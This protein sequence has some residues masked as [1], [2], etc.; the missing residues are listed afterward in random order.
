MAKFGLDLY[1]ESYYGRDVLVSYSVGDFTATQA[2]YGSIA[3]S[4]STPVQAQNWGS[5]RIIRNTAGYPASETDGDLLLEFGPDAPSNSFTDSN[6][7]GGRFYY[8]SV[9]LSSAF[10]V[11]DSGDIYQAGDTVSYNGSN[12]ICLVDNTLGVAPATGLTQWQATNAS[13]TWNRAGQACSLAVA[14]Y[15]YR[16]RLYSLLP[17]PYATDQEEI[18]S[19]Q[20]PENELLF[21]YLSVLAWGLDMTRT[22]L[23]DQEHLHRV[24][25]MPLYRME[26]LAQQL[27]VDNEASITPRLRRVRASNAAASARRKGTVEAIKEAVYDA[28]GYDSDVSTSKNL[29][30]DADQAEAY[31]PRWPLWDPSVTYQAGAVVS[32]NGF[33][34]SASSNTIRLEAELQTITL[35]GAP[36]YTV[37]A[38]TATAQ[39][40]GGQQVLIRSN[41]VNQAATF[42]ITIPST[43]SYDLS[44]GMS[45][46]PGFGIVNFA[47]DD[48]TVTTNRSV[49][50]W[51]PTS[52]KLAF[53]GYASSSSP[54]SSVYLG[55]FSLTAGT[56]TIQAKVVAKNTKATGTDNGY[57]MGVD[58]ITYTPQGANSGVGVAPTGAASNNA[59]W[60]YYT[61]KLTNVLD[62]VTSGGISTWE[63][64]SFTAGA[65][66]NNDSL[67]VYSGYKALNGVGD[68]RANL[69]VMTNG[70]GV[71]AT[72]A[73]HSIPRARVTAWNAT[74]NYAQG[75]Y[76][77]YGGANYICLLPT[78]GTAPDADLTHW[79]PEKISTTGTDR[80]LVSSYGIPLTQE[81]MWSGGKTYAPGDVVQYQGQV[82]RATVAVKGTAPTGFPTDNASWAWNMSARN[83]YT[84]SAYTSRYTGSGTPSRSIYIEW[85][86]AAGNL[87]TTI[88]PSTVGTNPDLFV[89]FIRNSTDVRNDANYAGEIAGLSWLKTSTDTPVA[90]SGL[91]YWGT[92]TSNVGTTTGRQLFFTYDRA[93]A[94]NVGI[95]FMTAPPAGVEHGIAFR[96]SG[97]T[98]MWSV[99]R[100][101]LAKN[102]AGTLT[103]MA[104]WP[105]LLDGTRVYVQLNGNAITVYR[106]QGAGLAPLQLASVT[107]AFNA[108]AAGIALF[109]RTY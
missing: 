60:T 107:D 1:G 58:Y 79:R 30:L 11:Y 62:N 7:V 97:P 17:T 50:T 82:Y 46:A 103:T 91:F 36:S 57:Q 75:A 94:I 108:T 3:L 9:F 31:S 90:S 100:T 69:A 95:T 6:L 27:G 63:Q 96:R 67:D 54:A 21:R 51:P 45:K 40:S 39:F 59:F 73:A 85:F 38:N 106:Y 81:S 66:A 42:T 22:E 4:W 34:Y 101:R 23:G 109:E 41:A 5:L 80:Y 44:I 53:D 24:S 49:F 47:V 102:V 28:T 65:T 56:H 29:M 87:I 43:G 61:A 55:R 14:D 83:V 13:K 86:D 52:I 68:N 89:P 64:V 48:V 77:S 92:R 88:N 99:S 20:D 19:P 104:S 76:V 10:P 26:L 72:L 12:W 33:L 71:S 37:Q 105:S 2:G 25:T 78:S 93:D 16:Q 32:Y 74:T 8:Y 84:A 35:N 70:T 98:D 15:G 18:T